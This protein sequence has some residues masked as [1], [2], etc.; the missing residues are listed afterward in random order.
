[1]K[2]ILRDLINNNPELEESSLGIPSLGYRSDGIAFSNEIQT[3]CNAIYFV[4]RETK[5]MK[6]NGNLKKYSFSSGDSLKCAPFKPCIKEIKKALKRKDLYSYPSAAG[7][8]EHKNKILDYLVKEKFKD[9]STDN[10]IFTMSTTHGYNLILETILRPYDVVLVPSPNYAFFNFA[11]ERLSASCALFG[12]SKEDNWLINCDKLRKRIDEIN[13]ELKIK[14]KNLSYTPRV[15]V[16][17]NCNPSNPTGKS[18]GVEQLNILNDLLDL[19]HEKDFF[20]IDDLVYQ[21][22]CFEEKSKPM[23]LATLG[24]HFSNTITMMG[25]SKSYGLA[26]LRSGI[27]VADELIIR[28]I[29]NKIFQTM[30]SYPLIQSAALAGAFNGSNKRYKYYEKYFKKI[31]EEYKFRYNL[32]VALVNGIDSVCDKKIRKRVYKF[33]NK[34]VDFLHTGIKEINFVENCQPAAGFFTILDFTSLKG[35]KYKKMIIENDKD[36]LKY[37]FVNKYVKFLIGSSIAYPEKDKLIARITFALEPEILV[38]SFIAI[39]EG[40]ELLR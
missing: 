28:E 21:D 33:L 5:K 39:K 29:T 23:P 31:N 17:L 1:M 13:D 6:V 26:S 24:K 2:K 37:F 27:V 14:Y 9:I 3:V 10:I 15:K 8:E 18:M 12:L 40:I 25:L 32:V 11:P 38:E 35:R 30:D 19:A 34:K 7:N 22:I 36:L 20:V 4:S 16:V